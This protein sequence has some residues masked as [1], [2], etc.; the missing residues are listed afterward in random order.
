MSEKL[1]NN[2]HKVDCFCI[3]HNIERKTSK[4]QTCKD[5]IDVFAAKTKIRQP[6]TCYTLTTLI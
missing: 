1:F 2:L 6:E 5:L 3:A 4:V